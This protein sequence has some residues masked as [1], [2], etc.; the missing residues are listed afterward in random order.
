MRGFR[1][2]RNINPSE[3]VQSHIRDFRPALEALDYDPAV[4]HLFYMVSYL[5]SG[6]LFTILRTIPGTH[7]DHLASTI[8][9][10]LGMEVDADRFADVVRATVA[11]VSNPSV[12]NEDMAALQDLFS[13]TYPTLDSPAAMVASE[14]TDYA[15]CRYGGDTGRPLELFFDDR[16]YQ[17]EYLPY[18]G[19]L[20]VDDELQAAF[21]GDDVSDI[22]PE[23]P[24]ELA[25]PE[26]DS[27]GFTPHIFGRTFDCPFLVSQGT[28]VDIVWTRN[29]F[30]DKVQT[31]AVDAGTSAPEAISA[32][33]ALKTIT[34]ASFHVTAPGG[35]TLSN[36]V[37][38][39]VNDEH[40][41]RPRE[42]TLA[43]LQSA[44]VRVTAPG[45][46]PFHG[47][48]D[49]ASTTRALVQLQEQRKVYRFEMPVK[50]TELGAPIHF[51]IHTKRELTDSPLEGYR[52]TDDM[53]EGHA[54]TNRLEYI[55][56]QAMPPRRSLAIGAGLL[57][58]G[59]I[60]GWIA[61]TF[62]SRGYGCEDDA[63][64]DSVELAPTEVPL[65]KAEQRPAKQDKP[66]PAPKET[67]TEPQTAP[68]AVPAQAVP[69]AAIAYLDGNT[70]WTREGLDAHPALK[71]LF[72]DMNHYRFDAITGKWAQALAKSTRFAKVSHHAS[73]SVRKKIFTPKGTYCPAGDNAI[74]VQT[75][76]NTIDPAKK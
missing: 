10:P 32:T 64:A 11:V 16:L 59:I 45:Y 39:I 43:E 48:I 62:T 50:S 52:L 49:L 2:V 13:A 51:E 55:G 4:K 29:G 73:E 27:D 33:D 18:A 72:D 71:G 42:F 1:S 14:G 74:A 21:E 44:D 37:S 26:G 61:A 20:L 12:S 31:V 19:V 57:V 60:L 36:S 69:A 66:H 5:D 6:C 56:A 28:E 68:A 8:F 75:Y 38:I 17:T 23:P 46:A 24:V 54:R 47:S 53:K 35:R 25:P 9:V 58:A 70:T 22:D 65:P 40:I 63:A 7:G 3:A 41:D 34:P 15:V 30:E 67:K 76:L